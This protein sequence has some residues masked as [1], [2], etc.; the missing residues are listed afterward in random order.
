MIDF[1]NTNRFSTAK[2]HEQL[3]M[4]RDNSTSR[5]VGYINKN[6]DEGHWFYFVKDVIS[7]PYNS[8]DEAIN[9]LISY[10]VAVQN[11][12]IAMLSGVYN[13]ERYTQGR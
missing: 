12:K 9:D 10:Y 2:V 3:F 1:A 4:L 5:I 8:Y 13:D 11:D 6:P 7:E